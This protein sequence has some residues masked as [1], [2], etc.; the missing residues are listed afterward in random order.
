MVLGARRVDRVEAIADD[1]RAAGLRA[2]GVSLDVTSEASVIAA[3]D[4][5]EQQFGVVETVIANAGVG[6]G[7]R[8]TD[9]AFDALRRTVDTNLIGTYLVAREGARRMIAGGSG[10][11]E[12]G[13]IVLIGSITA[14]QNH[15]GDA[16]YA[17]TKAG[18]SHLAK[19]FAKEWARQGINVNV[20]HP[21]WIRSAMNDQWSDTERGLQDI[22]RLPRKRLQEQSSLD[23]MVLYLCS[24]RSRQ[25]TGAVFTLDDGQSL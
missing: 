5:A 14:L 11:S 10:K 20:I 21:G 19:Q 23:D 15:T 9:L 12:S 4:C 25:I 13:R 3:Y 24:D 8:A 6:T 18:I 2:I 7:A 1:L 22:A 16:S 17:A